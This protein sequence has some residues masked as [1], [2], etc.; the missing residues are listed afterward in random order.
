MKKA[1]CF[2]GLQGSLRF[3]AQVR[4]E[5]AVAVEAGNRQQVQHGGGRLKEAHERDPGPEHPVL[6]VVHQLG[7]HQQ[8]HRERRR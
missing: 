7:Q 5:R 3:R 6:R 4:F 1:H 8:H 2:G